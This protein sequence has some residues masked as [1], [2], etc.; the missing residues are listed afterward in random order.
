MS[1]Q[2]ER[3]LARIRKEIDELKI[4]LAL[5]RAEAADYLEEQKGKFRQLVDTSKER[6]ERNPMIDK[7]TTTY[8]KGRLDELRLQL[9]LGKMESREAYEQQRAKIDKAI[10]SVKE[11]AEPLK[12]RAGDAYDEF[13]EVF[14]RAAE[15]FRAKLGAFGLNLRKGES[16][17]ISEEERKEKE[18]VEVQL[19]L[20]SDQAQKSEESAPP[21]TMEKLG[22]DLDETY[23]QLRERLSNL[24][25]G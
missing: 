14:G 25:K 23:R 16:E 9:A 21:G 1:E 8:L 3:L 10:A 2:T 5:G 6:L 12:E 13:S 17:E 20:L 7:Q 18:A 22:K 11:G 19:E 4:Q 15:L 24:F